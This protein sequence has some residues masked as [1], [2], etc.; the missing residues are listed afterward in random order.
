MIGVPERPVD[1]FDASGEIRYANGRDEVPS[2]LAPR[3]EA[4]RGAQR[5]NAA[6]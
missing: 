4:E 5:R 6:A 2:G 1:G 3:L